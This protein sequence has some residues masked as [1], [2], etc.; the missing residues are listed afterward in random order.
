MQAADLAVKQG[1][2][3]SCVN[4]LAGTFEMGKSEEPVTA[5]ASSHHVKPAY[6]NDGWRHGGINMWMEDQ[7]GGNW[8]NVSALKQYTYASGRLKPRVLTK[9]RMSDHKRA[10]KYI[11][12]FRRLGIMPY[13]RLLAKIEKDPEAK[14]PARK[15][16]GS[17]TFGFRRDTPSQKGVSAEVDELE[18][19]G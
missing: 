15:G 3:M 7:L 2:V 11:K 8:M 5:M 9:L 16:T 13:H 12:R 17:G 4:R 19:S 18:K 14:R 10:V 1:R 6:Y